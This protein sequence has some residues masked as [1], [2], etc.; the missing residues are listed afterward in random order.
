LSIR[1]KTKNK[2]SVTY[3]PGLTMLSEQIIETQLIATVIIEPNCWH[4]ISFVKKED[5][6]DSFL[7][8]VWDA[9]KNLI[10]SGRR[11]I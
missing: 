6:S 10:I 8:D 9:I 7:G 1:I 2:R 4:E 3:K 11:V 5:F